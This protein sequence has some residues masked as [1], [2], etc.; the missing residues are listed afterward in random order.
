MVKFVESLFLFIFYKKNQKFFRQKLF[1]NWLIRLLYWFLKKKFLA[2]RFWKSEKT[3]FECKFS[4]F[5]VFFSIS[6][7]VLTMLCDSTFLE[8]YFFGKFGHF[9]I[10]NGFS[11]IDQKT[12]SPKTNFFKFFIFMKRVSA[13]QSVASYLHR[14]R[15]VSKMAK[16]L[17]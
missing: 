10:W 4:K 17:I 11:F 1:L 5:F 13:S 6:S 15:P 12:W 16:I 14:V 7:Q 2:W 3:D 9:Y 8:T